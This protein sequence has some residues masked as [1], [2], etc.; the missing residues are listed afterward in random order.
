MR[1]G[2]MRGWIGIDNV[3]CRRVGAKERLHGIA[4]HILKFDLGH[5]AVFSPT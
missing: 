1:A 4:Q 2:Q 5:G 3:L